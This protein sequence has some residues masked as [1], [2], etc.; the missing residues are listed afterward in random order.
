[1]GDE[2]AQAYYRSGEEQLS[3][4]VLEALEAAGRPT[5]PIDPDDLTGL[6]E[7]HG[8]GRA[9]T[10]ALADLAGIEGGAKVLDVGAGIGGPARTLARHYG[11]AV[12][13]L[14]PTERFCELDEEL[15]RR[16][17][18]A[19]RVEVVCADARK[20]P[21][22]DAGFDF[23]LTQAVWPS[24]EDKAA[25]L[26]EIHRVLRPGGRLAI[27]E[28]VGEPAAGELQFPVPW[29]DGPQ[30]SFVI[31]AERAR[32][33]AEAAGFEVQHWLAAEEVVARIGTVAASGREEMAVG[34]D[35][36]DLSLLMPNFEAR[37]KGLAA[38]VE[39]GRIGLQ[40]AVLAK[41]S[42]SR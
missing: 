35:G 10:L 42:P 22:D 25:M 34:I 3:A 15:C 33:L 40:M 39:A 20:M 1:M 29:A 32:E 11:V 27:Y 38:N 19:D 17:R 12:T 7:F 30:E 9:A 24:V 26:A 18:L 23:A 14:D 5:D 41:A 37:M 31:S 28:I 21:L 16:S 8:L 6:D 4:V 2:Q 36:L 13:A